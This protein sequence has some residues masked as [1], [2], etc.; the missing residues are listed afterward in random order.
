MTKPSTIL[1]AAFLIARSVGIL[2]GP[3]QEPIPSD[4][5]LM[6]ETIVS[7]LAAGEKCRC[8]DRMQAAIQPL[9]FALSKQNGTVANKVLVALST[10]RL[11]VAND[12]IYQCIL[13][14]RGPQVVARLMA[15][16]AKNDCIQ[17]LGTGSSLCLSEA[18]R[19][20]VAEDVLRA[21]KAGSKCELE[22]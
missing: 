12:E 13:Q 18:E 14:R 22:Y 5:I 7:V 20:H 2:A 4:P 16:G 17:R 15:K 19:K 11:G 21:I 3:P 9:L 8:I 10:Y 1:I 6:Q